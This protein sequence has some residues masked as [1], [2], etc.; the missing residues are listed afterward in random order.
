MFIDSGEAVTVC[1]SAFSEVAINEEMH[2]CVS[3][4]GLS[5]S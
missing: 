2:L 4:S 1:E 3:V 5:E